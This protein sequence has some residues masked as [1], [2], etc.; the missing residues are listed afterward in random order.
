MLRIRDKLVVGPTSRRHSDERNQQVGPTEPG[1]RD[2]NRVDIRTKGGGG[3]SG[4]SSSSSQ[5]TTKFIAAASQGNQEEVRALLEFG[6]MDVD[7]GDYDR[8]TALHLAAGEG[9]TEMVEL[10][11][12]AGADVNVQDRWGNRPLDDARNARKNSS[13]IVKLL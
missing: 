7:E 1:R 5:Q 12:Q 10:L 11:C 3:A 9:R 4:S 2:H 13:R 6:N 8:R